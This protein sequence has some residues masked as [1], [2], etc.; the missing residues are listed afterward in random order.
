MN[1]TL[2]DFAVDIVQKRI[3]LAINATLNPVEPTFLDLCPSDVHPNESFTVRF[4]PGW[5]TAEVEFIPGKFSAPL[6]A[7]MGMAGFDSQSVLV[8]FAHALS[9][10]KSRVT[11]R[12]NGVDVSAFD[13]TKWPGSWSRVELLVRSAPQVINQDDI[14]QMRRLIVELVI[15]VFGM[16]VALV[17]VEETEACVEGEVE[18]APVW[19]LATRY[20]RKKINRE[21]CIQLKGLRCAAC[22]FDFGAFYGQLGD[23]YVEVH[24][25]T[26]LSDLGPGYRINVSTDLVPLCA[27]CHAMVHREDPPISVSRLA[28][29]I[30]GRR[31]T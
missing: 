10:R 31:E 18:G 25:T 26:P 24:H 11:F 15:P 20:E 28:G 14:A 22:G 9:S 30:T 2:A 6:I 12:I 23:G 13:S 27:N 19:S 3:G 29:L 8:A 4:S 16:V 1:E 5:R 21:A 17:G 7:Q